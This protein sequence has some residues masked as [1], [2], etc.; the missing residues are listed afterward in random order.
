MQLHGA[1]L[2]IPS[3][4]N[5]EIGDAIFFLNQALGAEDF[6]TD[7]CGWKQNCTAKPIKPKPDRSRTQ[8]KLGVRTQHAAIH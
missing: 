2:E 8:I 1:R 5:V 4:A 6:V 7:L 3:L